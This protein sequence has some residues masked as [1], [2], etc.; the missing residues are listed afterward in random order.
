MDNSKLF[1]GSLV[2]LELL[3]EC[4]CMDVQSGTSKKCEK[5]YSSKGACSHALATLLQLMIDQKMY[6]KPCEK[7]FIDRGECEMS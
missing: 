4:E 5:F 2:N 6:P 3:W 1:L 7:W